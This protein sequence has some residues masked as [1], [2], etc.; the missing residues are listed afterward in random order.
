MKK[1]ILILLVSMA[2]L[3]GILSGC[4][5][6]ETPPAENNAPVAVILITQD[7]LTITY[8]ATGSTDADGDTLTYTWAFGD[9]LGTSTDGTGT[10]PYAASGEYIVTLTANDGTDDSTPVTET[11]TITNPPIVTLGD[12]PETIANE[13]IITFEATVV[14][15]DAVVNATTGYAWSIDNGTGEVVQED[16]TAATFIAS[17]FG[18]YGTFVVKV[19]ATDE[20]GFTAT[21][22]VTVTVP[23]EP[24]A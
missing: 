20:L 4:T 8:D 24:E 9:E 15:G 3:V 12:L 14:E 2:L 19:I 23:T 21:A 10:Y 5:E 11:L 13:T 1:K 16:E 22:T 7:G 6:E 18:E 17:A